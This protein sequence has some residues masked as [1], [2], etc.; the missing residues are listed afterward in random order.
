MSSIGQDPDAVPGERMRGRRRP[1]RG[2][3][4]GIG[5]KP[6]RQPRRIFPPVEL[7][8]A[9]RLEAI[10]DASLTILE[11]I[12]MDFLHEEAKAILRQAGATVDP[13]SDRVRFDR[14]MIVEAIK[15]CP[16]EF[17]LHARNPA[18]DIRFGGNWLAF[19]EIGECAE[20]HRHGSRPASRQP[21]GFP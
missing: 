10:H 11:E 7:V 19:G 9:D 8:S 1:L 15:T 5:Q 14:G 12:G 3:P 6:F 21:A 18:H 20:L 2:G 17:K 4:V 16:S 13:A